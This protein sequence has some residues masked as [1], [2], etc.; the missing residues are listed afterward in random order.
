[1][2]CPAGCSKCTLLTGTKVACTACES[3]FYLDDRTME[4]DMCRPASCDKRGG[5]VY[6]SDWEGVSGYYTEMISGLRAVCRSGSG[7]K[8]WAKC[9]DADLNAYY[10]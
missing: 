7:C 5:L 2:R 4:D 6:S 8:G 3:R 1:M 10:Y 9:N